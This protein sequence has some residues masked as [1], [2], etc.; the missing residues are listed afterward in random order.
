M[1]RRP[2][3]QR[4]VQI[5]L[6]NANGLSTKKTELEEFVQTHQLDAVLI[7]ETHLI[8][9]LTLLNFR[10]YRT[11]REDVRGGGTAIL[12]KSTID[13]DGDL[14]LDLI[15]IEATAVTVNLA[16]G[17]VKV[18]AAYKAPNRQLFGGRPIRD[19]RH[20][21][22]GYP[23]RGPQREA[24]VVELEAD[25]RQRH[26]STQLRRRSPPAGGRYC[27]AHDIPA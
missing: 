18:V 13:H 8:A 3:K 6:W 23:R 1:N 26:M 16:T 27:L 15:N 17:P 10:V 5:A 11:D 20:P 9:R 12:V 7:G 19:L 21:G 2:R 25:E 4:S 14:A 24:P 22:S